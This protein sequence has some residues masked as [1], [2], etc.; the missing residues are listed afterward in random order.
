MTIIKKG[1]TVISASV[2]EL[3]NK[4]HLLQVKVDICALAQAGTLLNDQDWISSVKEENGYLIVE[5][6][7]DSAS[8][9]NQ[10][11]AEHN[12]FASELVTRSVSLERVFLDLTGGDGGA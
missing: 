4:G 2:K 8:Q 11:L 9:V 1:V 12:I 7:K 6:P 5:A 3:I 10:V